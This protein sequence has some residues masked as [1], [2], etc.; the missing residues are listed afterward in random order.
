MSEQVRKPLDPL[1]L[2]LTRVALNDEGTK[3]KFVA[4]AL[5]FE[6]DLNSDKLDKLGEAPTLPFGH[7]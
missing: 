3:L 5:Q 4:E 2:P 1:Q 6:Y 7:S